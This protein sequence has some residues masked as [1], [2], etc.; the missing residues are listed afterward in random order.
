MLNRSQSNPLI[1]F[2]QGYEH[3]NPHMTFTTKIEKYQIIQG[4]TSSRNRRKTLRDNYLFNKV[5]EEAGALELSKVRVSEIEGRP[6][7]EANL[8]TP[9]RIDHRKL[10]VKVIVSMNHRL[11]V[12]T[13][14]LHMG[15]GVPDCSVE[16]NLGIIVP[17][18][19][20]PEE[21]EVTNIQTMTENVQ[22]WVNV[23]L[24]QKV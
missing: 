5:S 3:L 1:T 18:R 9:N 20:E 14:T 7:Q 21:T 8:Y 13:S 12:V 19:M 23:S 17:F 6:A 24:L 22:Q 10:V 16:Q 15:V 4:F 11:V 2:T